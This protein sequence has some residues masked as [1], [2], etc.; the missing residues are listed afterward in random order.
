MLTLYQF[1]ISRFRDRVD[2]ATR[3]DAASRA[4]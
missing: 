2:A 4:A 1:E 3:P